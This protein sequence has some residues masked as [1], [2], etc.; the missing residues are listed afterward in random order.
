MIPAHYLATFG[1]LD[2]IGSMLELGNKNGT[3]GK[4]D[5]Y[6]QAFER[7]GIRH[8]SV[9]WNG[10]DGAVPLDLRKPL[11]LGVF[12]MVT[13]VGTSEHVDEQEPVWR[14][15]V[16]ACSH[17]LVCI[18][19]APGDWPGHGLF[20]PEPEF[21]RQLA[22]LNGFE[23]EKLAVEGEAGRRFVHFRG[24]RLTYPAFAMP[25]PALLRP[26]PPRAPKRR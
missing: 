9:D 1:P 13:N 12:D 25:D 26:A 21:Y 17:V 10:E 19:P 8:V 22:A 4:G 24:I 23:I 11:D 5:S 3:G 2:E 18:T 16:E 7:A 15:M 14:N 6:K 20:Y